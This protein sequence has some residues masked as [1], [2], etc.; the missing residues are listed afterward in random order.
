MRSACLEGSGRLSATACVWVM[1][2]ATQ[3]PAGTQ[4]HSLQPYVSIHSVGLGLLEAPVSV[5]LEQT[6]NCVCGRKY[7]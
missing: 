1:S 5:E 3:I 2:F 4:D 6:V 7:L